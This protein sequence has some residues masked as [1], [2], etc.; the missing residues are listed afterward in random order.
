MLLSPAMAYVTNS[1]EKVEVSSCCASKDSTTEK[2]HSE[3]SGD[4]QHEGNKDCCG[5]NCPNSDCCLHLNAYQPLSF[6]TVEIS[7]DEI[8]FTFANQEKNDF[9][10]SF[11]YQELIYSVWQPPKLIS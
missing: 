5:T 2:G 11:Y 8:Q 7:A 10:K 6:Q 9:Y 4:C 1:S 3:E